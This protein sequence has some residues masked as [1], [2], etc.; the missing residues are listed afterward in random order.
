MPDRPGKTWCLQEI[1][2]AF[3][4]TERTIQRWVVD[5]L[6]KNSDGTYDLL[7]VHKWLLDKAVSAGAGAYLKDQKLQEEIRKL[8]LSNN[9][10]AELY[11]LRTEHE[12][13]MVGRAV[14]LRDYLEKSYQMTRPER[15]MRS[16]EELAAIDAEYVQKMMS[17]YCGGALAASAITTS[18]APSSATQVPA[19]END[20]DYFNGL[21]NGIS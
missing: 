20:L 10:I 8:Q 21:L 17:A 18:P 6:Q 16:V 19:P 12:K 3:E 14:M 13:I 7:V 2:A 9:K 1:A 11:I 15:S 4:V 5:G